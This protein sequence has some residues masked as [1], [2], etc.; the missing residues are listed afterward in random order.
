MLE[1]ADKRVRMAAAE[2]L[3]QVGTTAAVEPLLA[4]TGGI[5][6]GPLKRAAREAVRRIQARVVGA[7]HGQLSVVAPPEPEGAVSLAEERREDG[8]VSLS[9]E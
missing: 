5:V 3:G 6:P 7:E 8:A 4:L 9:D 2:A 1:Q